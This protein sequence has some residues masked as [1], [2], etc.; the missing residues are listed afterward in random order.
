MFSILN[1]Y[2]NYKWSFIWNQILSISISV[3]FF[4]FPWINIPKSSSSDPPSLLESSSELD[5]SEAPSP[6]LSTNSI[7]PCPLFGPSFSFI[8]KSCGT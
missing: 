1:K 5:L 6:V 8:Y 2:T 4:L 7:P 3:A